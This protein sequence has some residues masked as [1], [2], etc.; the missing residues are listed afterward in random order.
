M[1]YAAMNKETLIRRSVG[2]DKLAEKELN[3]RDGGDIGYRNIVLNTLAEYSK[4][5]NRRPE[6]T[7]SEAKTVL[8]NLP[9]NNIGMIEEILLLGI[10]EYIKRKG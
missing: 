9:Q 3:K 8:E 10:V 5:F 6:V 2:G 7:V 4:K 1:N